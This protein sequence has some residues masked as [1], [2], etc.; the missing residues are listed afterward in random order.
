[1]AVG[2]A[3]DQYDDQKEEVAGTGG[4]TEIF[5]VNV[6]TGSVDCGLPTLVF[7]PEDSIRIVNLT[8]K[9]GGIYMAYHLLPEYNQPGRSLIV[10]VRKPRLDEKVICSS[11]GPMY[12]SIFVIKA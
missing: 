6:G 4:K 3:W 2:C 5:T 10:T 11:M 9:S 1:M 7:T 12:P 8:G